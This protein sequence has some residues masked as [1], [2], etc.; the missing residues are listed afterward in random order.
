VTYQECVDYLFN[1]HRF[2]IRLGLE[3]MRRLCAELGNPE[4]RL[5]FVHIA[6]TNGKGSTAAFL[7]SVLRE[8]GYCTGL[9]TSPHLIEMGE[10]IRVCGVQI[11]KD[12]IVRFTL[13]IRALIEKHQ[14]LKDVSFFEFITAMALLYFGEQKVKIVVWETGLGGRLDA[15]NVVDPECCVITGIGYDHMEYLGDTLDQIAAEKAGILKKGKPLVMGQMASGASTVI[16][17]RAGELGCNVR[18]PV[19]LSDPGAMLFRMSLPSGQFSFTAC[20]EEWEL[21]L[22]GNYQY[23]NALLVLEICDVLEECGWI[24]PLQAKK[25]GLENVCWPGRFDILGAEPPWVLDGAHNEEGLKSALASWKAWFQNPPAQVIFGCVA[26]KSLEAMA[27]L[28]HETE[29]V[30]LV[31]LSTGR[32]QSLNHMKNTFRNSKVLCHASLAEAVAEAVASGQSTLIVG[33]L[34]LAGE[35]LALVKHHGHEIKLNG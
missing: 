25:K 4:Q 33:S 15:T 5:K 35:Y 8:S 26:D 1:L 16:F 10:R 6:G 3:K 27:A 18:L 21:G 14:E 24:I 34:Y 30:R 13:R 12:D 31:E 7:E 17:R 2:G 20:G 23:I 28:L 19:E 11:P 32:S 22:K 9:Y 29:T